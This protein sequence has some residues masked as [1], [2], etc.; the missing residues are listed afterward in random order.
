M[1]VSG[2]ILPALAALALFACPG[3]A[4]AQSSWDETLK[5]AVKE[6]EVDVHGGPGELYENALKGAFR[7]DYPNIKI[8]F[9]GLGGRNAIPKVLREREAGI[10]TLDVYVGGTLSL[11]QGLKPMGAL[12][13]LRQAFLLPEVT[14][15]KAWYGGF[16]SGWMDKDRALVYGFEAAVNPTAM[17]NWDFVSHDD[18]KTFE[19][20]LKPQFAGKIV[21]DDPRLPGEGSANTQR[22]LVN[23]GPDFL[24]RLFAQQKIVYVTNQ[25]QHAEWVV[26]GQYPIGIGTPTEQLAPFLRQGLGRNVAPLDG[27]LPRPTYSAAFGNVVVLDRAP[28]PNGAKIYLNWLL[29]KAGQTAWST[30]GHNSRRLDVPHGAPEFFPKPGVAYQADQKEE[31]IHLREEAVAIAKQYISER[32]Q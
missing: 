19:D 22:L 31:N 24:K 13:P 7:R 5:A 1:G 32:T 10:Y 9:S 4:P 6:G 12:A 3:V 18:L 16:E 26:R 30:T 8:N 27:P 15:D 25:R 21:Y 14:D 28:H 20:L 2:R 11:L 29:S 23:F 17:V